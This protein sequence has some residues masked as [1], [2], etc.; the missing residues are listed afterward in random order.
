MKCA[1]R[2]TRNAESAARNAPRREEKA[3]K[4]IV[5]ATAA[6]VLA[7][8]AMLAAAQTLYKLIDKNGKVTYSESPPKPGEFDGQVVR[9]DI[10]PTRNTATL[11]KPREPEVKAPASARADSPRDA[12]RDVDGARAKLDA[13]RK[14]LAQAQENPADGDVSFIGNKGG[15]TRAVQTDAYRAKL[16]RLE[17]EVKQAEEELRRAQGG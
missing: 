5:I 9:I 7:S 1:S 8:G 11:P 13:A 16:D 15:G 6:A 14:A 2:A 10:D 3:M 17:A 12:G 4:R